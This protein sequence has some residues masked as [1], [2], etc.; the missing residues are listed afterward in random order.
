MKEEIDENKEKEVIQKAYKY[1]IFLGIWIIAVFIIFL[2]QITKI[3]TDQYLTLGFGL[4]ILIY[5]IA[6][7]TQNHKLKIKSIASILVYGLNILSVIGVV[8]II[9]ANQAHNLLELAVGVLLGLVTLILQVSAAI[10]A[11]L[12]A[13]KLRKLYPDILDNR[14]KNTN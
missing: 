3:I 9:L 11:L 10:F 7:H 1:N 4:I 8:L 13:R 5:A 2:L 6:L 12:S 14:R